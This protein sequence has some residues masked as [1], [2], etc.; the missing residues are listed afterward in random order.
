VSDRV[1]A[2][3]GVTR[4]TGGARE[5]TSDDMVYSGR[6]HQPSL[7]VSR[8]PQRCLRT[9]AEPAL[10]VKNGL[11]YHAPSLVLVTL[12]AQPSLDAYHRCL[13]P[14][15]DRSRASLEA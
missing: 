6:V 15:R 2:G 11:Y 13:A 5:A 7:T 9:A 3:G 8:T 12:R 1:R 4:V 14:G 10:N